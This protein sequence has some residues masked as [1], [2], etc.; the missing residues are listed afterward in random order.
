MSRKYSVRNGTFL[1]KKGLKMAFLVRKGG[2]ALKLNT[3]T[4]KL[5]SY[6]SATF[7]NLGF[8]L[9]DLCN[10][11]K[12]DKTLQDNHKTNM[13]RRST[14][15]LVCLRGI[16]KSSAIYRDKC[17]QSW[18]SIAENKG[19]EGVAKLRVCGKRCVGAL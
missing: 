5:M 18:G 11:T 6:I 7:L 10:F 14:L 9:L 2:L 17:G 1:Q 13:R 19:F 12:T 3:K 15:K 4:L 16:S 8:S